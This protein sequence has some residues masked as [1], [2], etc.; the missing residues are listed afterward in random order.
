M[1][2]I[3]VYGRDD[4]ARAQEAILAHLDAWKDE[5]RFAWPDDAFSVEWWGYHVHVGWVEAWNAEDRKTP[6]L[7]FL[8]RWLSPW[9]IGTPSFGDAWS[10]AVAWEL[11]TDTSPSTLR[12]RDL[13][14]V[15]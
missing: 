5:D 14:E 11:R 3:S 15:L 10:Q 2:V 9:W 8:R 12:M 4:A 6:C 13:P 7:L 1:R